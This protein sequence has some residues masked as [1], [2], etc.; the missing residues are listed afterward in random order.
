MLWKWPDT[1]LLHRQLVIFVRAGAECYGVTELLGAGDVL[2]AGDPL[3]ADEPLGA[4]ELL[5]LTELLG[6]GDDF[7][8]PGP[9]V[10]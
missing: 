6:D 1:S 2:G 10:K 4:G 3:G 8:I 7:G 5:G 9:A